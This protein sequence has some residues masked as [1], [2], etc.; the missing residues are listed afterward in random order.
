MAVQRL[1]R[2]SIRRNNLV[3]ILVLAVWATIQATTLANAED[4]DKVAAEQSAAQFWFG[5]DRGDLGQLYQSLSSGF[6]T[7]TPQQQ[8]VQQTGM[9][10]IQGGGPAQTRALVGSQDFTDL[11]GA[12]KGDY[13]YVRFKAKYSNG[14]VFQDAYLQKSDKAWRIWSF[15]VLAAPAD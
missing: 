8:F 9:M 3:L 7:V 12:P 10:R 5:F 13:F 2:R 14:S 6:R 11:P 4:V 15:N 1:F